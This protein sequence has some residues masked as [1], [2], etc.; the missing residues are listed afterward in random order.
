VERVRGREEEGKEGEKEGKFC[1]P[2]EKSFP[3]PRSRCSFTHTRRYDAD[4]DDVGDDC[5]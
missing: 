1:S 2:T 4:D 5:V 3:H